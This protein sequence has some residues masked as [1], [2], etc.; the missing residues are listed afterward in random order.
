MNRLFVLGDPDCP[1][2]RAFARWLTAQEQL[3][4]ITVLPAGS[5]EARARI[6]GLDHDAT[7]REI[8]VVADSGEV[9]SKGPAWVV[10]LWALRAHRGLAER[11]ATPAGLP[12]ARAAATAAAGLREVIGGGGACDYADGGDRTCTQSQGAADAGGDR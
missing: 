3:V 12:F 11:L 4:P 10:C 5:A 9:W 6:P 1:L 2:C 7:L 8:T